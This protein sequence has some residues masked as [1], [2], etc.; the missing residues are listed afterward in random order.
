MYLPTD[1]FQKEQSKETAMAFAC[2]N[3]QLTAP[4]STPR[5]VL[6]TISILKQR[7]YRELLLFAAAT[8]L[9]SRKRRRKFSLIDNDRSTQ[10]LLLK[11][12]LLKYKRSFDKFPGAADPK[13]VSTSHE[14]AEERKS[15]RDFVPSNRVWKQ[16]STSI[17]SHGLCTCSARIDRRRRTSS[18]CLSSMAMERFIRLQCDQADSKLPQRKRPHLCLL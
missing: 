12:K 14:S 7:K 10:K 4:T 1:V 6:P 15:I 17:S 18:D 8:K 5:A 13:V 11:L 3:I 2:D 9:W 16:S